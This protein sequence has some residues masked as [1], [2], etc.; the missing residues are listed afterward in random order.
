MFL[1]IKCIMTLRTWVIVLN[2]VSDCSFVHISV[3]MSPNS[4]LIE[5]FVLILY[6]VL[7]P[8]FTKTISIPHFISFFFLLILKSCVLVS[9]GGKQFS[10][11]ILCP[12][13]VEVCLLVYLYPCVWIIINYIHSCLLG[14]FFFF[15]TWRNSELPNSLNVLV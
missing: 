1:R 3:D 6:S 4:T 11:V 13:V 14:A 8:C 7:W 15:V 2:K 9:V 10:K 5:S 12:H